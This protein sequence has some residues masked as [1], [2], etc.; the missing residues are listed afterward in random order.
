MLPRI[1]GEKKTSFYRKLSN[2]ELVTSDI[3]GNRQHG[4]PSWV[5]DK[6]LLL[7]SSFPNPTHPILSKTDTERHPTNYLPNKLQAPLRL[8]PWN[9]S[10]YLVPVG[11]SI[12]RR[13]GED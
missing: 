9:I 3:H 8:A 1:E 11:R 6:D 13:F 12:W 5:G 7:W 2:T 4:R 10:E